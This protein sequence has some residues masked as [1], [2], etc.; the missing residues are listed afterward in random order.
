MISTNRIR[1][2]VY[3]DCA[4]VSMYARILV[5]KILFVSFLAITRR[6][7]LIRVGQRP[8]VGVRQSKPAGVNSEYGYLRIT[9]TT[10]NAREYRLSSGATSNMRRKGRRGK[11]VADQARNMGMC[12]TIFHRASRTSARNEHL[13][14]ASTELNCDPSVWK[15]LLP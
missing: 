2:L 6:A 14:L 4:L 11:G 13:N 7:A 9:L 5:A 15:R 1:H 12:T 8:H 3:G 10:R